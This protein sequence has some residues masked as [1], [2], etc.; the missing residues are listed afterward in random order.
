MQFAQAVD[1]YLSPEGKPYIE[2]L[3]SV[4]AESSS[5]ESDA[6][7]LGYAMEGIRLSG[8]FG[9]L[10]K[11]EADDVIVEDDGREVEVKAGDHVIMSLGSGA[12]EARHFPDPDKVDPRRPLEAYIYYGDGPQARLAREVNQ[13]ALPELF[14]TI[15]RRKN[16]RRVAGPQGMLKKVPQP[17]GS[18]MCLTEDWGS[19]WPFPTTMKVTWD[20]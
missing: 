10:R 9:F 6:L 13:V 20:E 11:A 17:G 1:F 18:F 3:T 8:S 16:L 7:L 12:K 4:A 2:Q 15:F 19:L 5:A 14:R